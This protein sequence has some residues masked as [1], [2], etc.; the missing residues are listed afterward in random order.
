[1]FP[2]SV[3]T[4]Q[5]EEEGAALTQTSHATTNQAL[6]RGLERLRTEMSGLAAH[7][8]GRCG[9]CGSDVMADETHV[10]AG[11]DVLHARCAAAQDEVR[12]AS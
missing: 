7:R 3:A 6:D 11:S 10:V 2:R 1:M 9:G 12:R 5:P 4:E 8:V